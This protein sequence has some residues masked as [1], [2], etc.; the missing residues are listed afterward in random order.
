MRCRGPNAGACRPSRATQPDHPPPLSSVRLEQREH[1]SVVGAG[2]PGEVPGDQV[3]EVEVADG[4]RVLVAAHRPEHGADRPRTDAARRAPADRRP[5]P[6]AAATQ[7][8][9]RSATR[10]H[11]DRAPGPAWSRCRAGGTTTPAGRR[12]PRVAAAASGRGRARARARRAAAH[13][14]PPLA[15]GLAGRD[16]LLDDR[17]A[18]ARGTGR[19]WRRPRG[20]GGGGPTR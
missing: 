20:R 18:A 6:A 11:G 4:D 15:L 7:S 9:K 10:G 5:R 3:G 19:R 14:W 8:H 13:S 1:T 12:A 17:R 16:A 2:L